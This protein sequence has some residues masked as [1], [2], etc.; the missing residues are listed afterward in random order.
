MEGCWP[1]CASAAR[2]AAGVAE[3]TTMANTPGAQPLA[4]L[5]RLWE[6]AGVA[7]ADGLIGTLIPSGATRTDKPRCDTVPSATGH[8]R[9]W[10]LVN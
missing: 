9:S 5:G 4:A 2:Y 1:T 8:G 3:N 6:E 10:R 7:R